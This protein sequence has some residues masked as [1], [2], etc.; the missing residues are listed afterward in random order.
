MTESSVHLV[1]AGPHRAH[2]P[3]PNGVLALQEFAARLGGCSAERA[4]RT[5]PAIPPSLLMLHLQFI[6]AVK[7]GRR[8]IYYSGRTEEEKMAEVRIIST[9]ENRQTSKHKTLFQLFNFI[10]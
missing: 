7:L 2:S 4:L 8:S 1:W 5:R 9:S 6:R 3:G 10:N